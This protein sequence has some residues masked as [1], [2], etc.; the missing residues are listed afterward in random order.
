[1]WQGPDQ[2]VLQIPS[3]RGK[4]FRSIGALD[5]KVGLHHYEVLDTTNIANT[6][7]VFIQNLVQKLNR[8]PAVLIMENLS[9]HH[10]IKVAKIYE[11]YP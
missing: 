8:M 3:H 2:L 4:S 5:K 10:S 1:M 9:V 6:F 11:S 7:S